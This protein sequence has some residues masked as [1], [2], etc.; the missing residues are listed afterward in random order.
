MFCLTFE[1]LLFVDFYHRPH[2]YLQVFQQFNIKSEAMEQNYQAHCVHL[3]AW[4]ELYNE[5]FRKQ[6]LPCETLFQRFFAICSKIKSAH[7]C[8]HWA[9]LKCVVHVVKIKTIIVPY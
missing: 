4:C 6:L 5:I 7:Y 8:V 1:I 3:F 9:G 2:N